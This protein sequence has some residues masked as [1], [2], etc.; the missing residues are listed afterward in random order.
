MHDAR[1]VVDELRGHLDR[2]GSWGYA[3]VR[4]LEDR[5]RAVLAALD[6]A[7][8]HPRD[9]GRSDPDYL[10]SIYAASDRAYAA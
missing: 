6:G 1:G 3:H 2:E 10:A 5:L 8:R 4:A 7:A 9:R